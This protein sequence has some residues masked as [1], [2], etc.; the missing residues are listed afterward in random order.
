M[1]VLT[2]TEQKHRRYF[3]CESC[4]NPDPMSARK[5]TDHLSSIH[6]IHQSKGKRELVMCLDTET[7]YHNTYQWTFRKVILTEVHFGP[8]SI[9]RTQ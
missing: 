5:I 3:Y 6:D 7:S 4:K 1:K 2:K 8:V 9:G